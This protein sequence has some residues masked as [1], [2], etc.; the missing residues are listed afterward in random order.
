MGWRGPYLCD[1]VW[2][3]L[4]P[5]TTQGDHLLPTSGSPSTH[6]RLHEA[7]RGG[8]LCPPTFLFQ[9]QHCHLSRHR[10]GPLLWPGG[11]GATPAFCPSFMRQDIRTEP[12]GLEPML[13]RGKGPPRAGGRPAQGCPHPGSL[14]VKLVC[15]LRL[16]RPGKGRA[17]AL[18]GR[19]PLHCHP[20]WEERKGQKQE[21]TA[22][23]PAQVTPDTPGNQP[24]A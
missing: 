5:T 23:L 4:P 7:W 3:D 8:Q 24:Q 22:V 17:G 13:F 6:C 15:P 16:G 2:S 10:P 1:R 12:W 20:C 14:P 11:R 19:G 9:A 21:G 18:G